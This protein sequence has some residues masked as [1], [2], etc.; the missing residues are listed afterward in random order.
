VTGLRDPLRLL[1]AAVRQRFLA[2]CGDSEGSR[3]FA[4]FFAQQAAVMRGLVRLRREPYIDIAPGPQLE[5]AKVAARKASAALD[6]LDLPAVLALGPGWIERLYRMKCDLADLVAAANSVPMN[7]GGAPPRTGRLEGGYR[8]LIWAA[9]A[10]WRAAQKHR[11]ETARF[12]RFLD[13]VME[14]AG[15]E[16]LSAKQIARFLP[17]PPPEKS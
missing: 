6:A 3:Y 10:A 15:I 11:R 5:R 4:T 17:K 1:H 9:S 13:D 16:P 14:A 7:P 2:C 12:H 8:N